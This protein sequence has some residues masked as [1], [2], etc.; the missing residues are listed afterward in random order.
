MHTVQPA[1]SRFWRQH[2]R[3][4]PGDQHKVL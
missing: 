4:G 2:W 1:G 3:R